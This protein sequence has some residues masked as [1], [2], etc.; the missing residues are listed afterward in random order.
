MSYLHT[1][2]KTG[3]NGG[4]HTSLSFGEADALSHGLMRIENCLRMTATRSLG[5]LFR[6]ALRTA[7]ERDDGTSLCPGDSSRWNEWVAASKTLNYCCEDPLLDWLTLFGESK[8]FIRDDQRAG[9]DLRTDFRTFVFERAARFEAAVMNYLAKGLPITR[10]ADGPADIHSRPHVEATWN[11]MCSGVEIIYQG[12]LW[13][14]ETRTYGSPDLLIRSDILRKL[15]PDYVSDEEARQVARDLP[16]RE[17]HYRVIDIKFTTLHLLKDGHAANHH[18]KHMVQCRIYNDALGRLQG[19][20]PPSS[21]LLGRRWENSKNRGNTA[22]ERLARID[23]ERYIKS[24]SSDLRS[25]ASNACDWVRRVRSEGGNWNVFPEPSVPELR[26]N[27]RRTDDQPW[28]QA[29]T[30]IARELADLTMLPRVTP[31]KRRQAIAVGVSRWNDPRCTATLLGIKGSD[32]VGIMDAV[33]K[34]NHSGDDGPIVFPDRL[35]V[36]EELWRKGVTPEFYVD[37]ETVSNL[38]D[39]FS[40]FP[41]AGGE[42]LIFMIGCGHSSGPPGDPA[43]TFRNFLTHSLSL[44]EERR[45]IDEWLHHMQGVCEESGGSLDRARVFHWSP[46]EPSNL[47]DAYNAAFVRQG[48]PTWPTL[49][50]VDLLKEVIKKQPVTVRGAFSFGLKAIA[51]AL[52]G[53]ALIETVWHDGSTDGLGAMTGAWWCHREAQRLNVSMQELDL[54][55]EIALYNEIDC[56]AMAEVVTYFRRHR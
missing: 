3:A 49:P 19:F 38:D 5:I 12:V 53:H 2:A 39:D 21:F 33:I 45:I 56:R 26:P 34:A 4:K 40:H 6:M 30:E 27:M 51:K 29:K 17:V 7:F 48:S 36:G 14:P 16:L 32:V 23:H 1:N 46:A 10:I 8:G 52:H 55:K 22:V 50:W 54:M 41:V 47:T 28:H 15:F 11:A 25:V 42:P 44:G 37:F 31:E 13:N 43:W 35:T 20:T 18:L 9:F 24:A